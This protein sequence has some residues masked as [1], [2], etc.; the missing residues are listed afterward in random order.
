MHEFLLVTYA[1]LLM[2]G[3]V[4]FALAISISVSALALMAGEFF[5][6][7]SLKSFGKM[8]LVELGVSGV[9]LILVL[10]LIMPNGPFDMAA[11][12]FAVMQPNGAPPPVC[13]EW[14]EAHPLVGSGSSAYYQ[15]GNL[16]FGYAEYFLGCEPQTPG[17]VDI[18]EIIITPQK[19]FPGVMSHKLA[20]GFFSMQLNEMFIGFLSGFSA[21]VNLPKIFAALGVGV[22][23]EPW[24]GLMPLVQFHTLL[25]D[26]LSHLLFATVGEKMLLQFI[27]E[28]VI[29]VFLPFGLLMRAFPFSRKT[30]STVIAL[31]FATYFV[32]PISVLICAQLYEMIANPQ[33]DS[34]LKAVDQPCQLDSDC[35]SGICRNNACTA[36]LTDFK[37]YQSLFSV[38]GK[39]EKD[40]TAG[41]IASDKSALSDLFDNTLDT[42]KDMFFNGSASSS[43]WTQ[44]TQRLTE[45]KEEAKRKSEAFAKLTTGL[46]VS[47]VQPGI[48]KHVVLASLETL[49]ADIGHFMVFT[50]VSIVLEIVITMTLFKDFALLIGGEPRVFGIT[51]LI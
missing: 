44:T 26:I 39:T 27:E 17:L 32:F 10:L 41:Q 24:A 21:N 9:I 22:G 18:F 35:C 34:G 1:D 30:G 31:V 2:N 37:E 15:D 14:E 47:M 43:K 8:E 20:V 40:T 23:I 28:S 4:L 36:Q 19:L 46:A 38:C 12:G 6:M 48:V 50:M 33:C 16:A 45:A 25:M 42:R 29:T 13:P 3:S 7:P 5:S 49:I 51:K 11:R